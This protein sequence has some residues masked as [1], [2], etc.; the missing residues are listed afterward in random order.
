MHRTGAAASRGT[1][2]HGD[3]STLTELGKRPLALSRPCHWQTQADLGKPRQG[4]PQA[5]GDE[6]P[7]GCTQQRLLSNLMENAV[8]RLLAMTEG[9]GDVC[10]FYSCY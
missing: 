8:Y 5:P 2:G 9:G 10:A 3:I 7:T 4:L 6:P 1:S